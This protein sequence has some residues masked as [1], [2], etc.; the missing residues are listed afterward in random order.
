MPEDRPNALDATNP[1]GSVV[2][3]ETGDVLLPAPHRPGKG[4]QT[5]YTPEQGAKILALFAQ[6]TPM[7]EIAEQVGITMSTLYKWAG[8]PILSEPLA[9]ARGRRAAAL[10]EEARGILDAVDPDKGNGNARVS[11]ARERA[12]YRRW[13]ASCLDRETWGERSQVDVRASV[14]QITAFADV[15]TT[16]PTEASVAAE[17]LPHVVTPGAGLE[18]DG[19]E[20]PSM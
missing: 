18:D 14:V 5:D 16:R 9:R 7:R 3:P 12:A 15:A 17:L 4:L 10:V 20:S 13:V 19:A 2:I 8:M 11:L 6:G 1:P